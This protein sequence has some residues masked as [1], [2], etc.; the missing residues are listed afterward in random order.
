MVWKVNRFSVSFCF[1]RAEI[2]ITAQTQIATTSVSVNTTFFMFV[3]RLDLTLGYSV[4]LAPIAFLLSVLS[5]ETFGIHRR[6]EIVTLA[7][8]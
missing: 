6:S 1:S 4:A 2:V 5:S 3:L 8:I 7:C